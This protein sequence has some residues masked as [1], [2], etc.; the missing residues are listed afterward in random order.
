MK[1]LWYQH[2]VHGGNSMATLKNR[3][4]SD[5]TLTMSQLAKRMYQ[6]TLSLRVEFAITKS[7]L[8]CAGLYS[9]PGR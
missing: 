1:I 9:T 4:P 5:E 6:L 8:K 7:I 2:K 3:L